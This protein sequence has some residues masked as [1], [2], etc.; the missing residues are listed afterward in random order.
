LLI[1]QITKCIAKQVA[2]AC[3]YIFVIFHCVNLPF[4]YKNAK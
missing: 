4:I 1:Y 2:V 3:N